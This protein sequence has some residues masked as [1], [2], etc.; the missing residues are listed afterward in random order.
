MPTIHTVVKRKGVEV[1][2]DLEIEVWCAKCNQGLCNQSEIRYSKRRHMP[3]IIVTPCDCC[4][5][6]KE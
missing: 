3:Q 1:E 5:K 6:D 2:I 4:D